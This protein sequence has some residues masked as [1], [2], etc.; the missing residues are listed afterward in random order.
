MVERAVGEPGEVGYRLLC[1]LGDVG[2]GELV[3]GGSALLAA[4]AFGLAP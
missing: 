4:A 1:E 3:V 2:A